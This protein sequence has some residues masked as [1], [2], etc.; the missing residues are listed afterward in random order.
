MLVRLGKLAQAPGRISSIRLSCRFTRFMKGAHGQP[1]KSGISLRPRSG[2]RRIPAPHESNKK[3]TQDGGWSRGV[4][5]PSD[6]TGA[7][8]TSGSDKRRAHVCSNMFDVSYNEGAGGAV[9]R[10][11]AHGFDEIMHNALRLVGEMQ[12]SSKPSPRF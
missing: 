11:V 8:E 3:S 7:A 1:V 6:H 10:L 5:I 12:S 4:W 9:P 2:N